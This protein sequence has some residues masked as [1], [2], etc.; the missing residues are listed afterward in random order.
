MAAMMPAGVGSG[1]SSD[2]P[3]NSTFDNDAIERDLIDPDDGTCPF[4]SFPP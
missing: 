1:G 2:T 4:T 3:Y